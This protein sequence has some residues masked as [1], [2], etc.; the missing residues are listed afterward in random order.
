MIYRVYIYKP[1][2]KK[3]LRRLHY[4]AVEEEEIFATKV[5]Y[6]ARL[7]SKLKHGFFIE[8][9]NHTENVEFGNELAEDFCDIYKVKTIQEAFRK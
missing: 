3:L 5:K 2:S 6:L 7:I 4:L 9:N 1:L 8:D